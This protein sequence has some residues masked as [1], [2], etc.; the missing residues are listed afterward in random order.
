LYNILIE[1]GIP[2][3]LFSAI[4]MNLKE[5]CSE[6]CI[7]KNLSDIS[8]IQNGLKQGDALSTFLFNFSL[9][10]AIVKVQENQGGLELNGTRQF[11]LYVDSFSVFGEN[12]NT[13]KKSS[14]TFIVRG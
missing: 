9:E 2:T 8:S 12:T 1:F 3:K 10:Y 6:V 4:K 5:T 11:L 7:G 13:L 14:E